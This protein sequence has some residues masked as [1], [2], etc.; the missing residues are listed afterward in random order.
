MFVF[1]KL[2]QGETILKTKKGVRKLFILQFIFFVLFLFSF[3]HF[4]LIIKTI[5]I[6]TAKSVASQIINESV[7]HE[8]SNTDFYNDI[9]QV[10]QNSLGEVVSVLSNTNKLNKLKSQVTMSVQKKLSK[11]KN[12]KVPIAVGTLTGFDM[13]NGIGPNIP[14][15]ISI[16]GNV[17]SEFK[18]DFKSSGINQTIYRVYINI[19]AKLSVIVPGCSSVEDFSTNILISETV[20]LGKVP[21]AYSIGSYCHDTRKQYH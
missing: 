5:S 2:D 7:L 12:K 8:L 19:H 4:K 21:K 10:Q 17:S 11:S 13:L 14:M 16:V 18:S 9:I 15:N 20:I 1:H 6:N 3:R